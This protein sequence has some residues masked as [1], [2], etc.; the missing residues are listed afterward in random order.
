MYKFLF[1]DSYAASRGITVKYAAQNYL[2]NPKLTGGNIA[3]QQHKSG[4]APGINVIV[5]QNEISQELCKTF[6]K[7]LEKLDLLEEVIEETKERSSAMSKT[8][9]MDY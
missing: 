6:F 1:L 5:K 3:H 2:K 9:R 8:P 4:S 7:K